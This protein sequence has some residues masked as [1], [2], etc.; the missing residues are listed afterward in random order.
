MI[1]EYCIRGHKMSETRKPYGRRRVGVCSECVKI[2]GP[3]YRNEERQK[4]Y[5]RRYYEANKEKVLE[6]QRRRYVAKHEEIRLYSQKWHSDNIERRKQYYLKNTLKREYGLTVDQYNAMVAEQHGLCAICKKPPPS[7]RRLDVD[8][9]HADGHVRQLLC[10]ECN[11]G[12]GCFKDSLEF[13]D[14]ALRYLRK[15]SQLRL[16]G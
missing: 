1:K 3:K 6:R 2:N 16:V 12:L 8:H 15:H 5:G 4:E 13:L 14:A 10:N 11:K 9:D 7:K